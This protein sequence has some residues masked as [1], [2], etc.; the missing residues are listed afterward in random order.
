[1]CLPRCLPPPFLC[2]PQMSL[3]L[4]S[5]GEWHPRS[6]EMRPQLNAPWKQPSGS[7]ENL[8][9]WRDGLG[10]G[11]WLPPLLSVLLQV[12]FRLVHCLGRSHAVTVHGAG[13]TSLRIGFP[14]CQAIRA[15][16]MDRVLGSDGQ[17]GPYWSGSLVVGMCL[18]PQDAAGSSK[19]CRF[20]L[21]D[22]GQF[23]RPL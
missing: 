2:L 6:L 13:P 17:R 20:E 19:P 23:T 10:P 12:R 4:W 8:G 5:P 22:L 21:C 9:T 1:M 18:C 14:G 15:V 7:P 16:R 11:S 3:G